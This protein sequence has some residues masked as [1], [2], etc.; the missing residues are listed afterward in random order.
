[1]TAACWGPA[2]GV[3]QLHA[4]L[5]KLA[6]RDVQREHIELIVRRA[7]ET[8]TP[9]AAWMLV[10]MDRTSYDEV[11]ALARNN[12]ISDERINAAVEELLRELMPDVQ[13]PDKTC[14]KR[15]TT[16]SR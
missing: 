5:V 15:I 8:L 16:E 2:A 11:I 10:R 12:G 6:D 4:A 1:V 9:L 13:R 14:N 3:R 7:G